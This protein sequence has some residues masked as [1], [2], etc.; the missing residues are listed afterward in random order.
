M[1]KSKRV[2]LNN[3]QLE[4]VI[5]MAQEEKRP[6]EAV[7]YTHLDVYKR[8]IFRKQKK[9][10]RKKIIKLLKTI[11]PI[12]TKQLKKIA[13]LEIRN[14]VKLQRQLPE[15]LQKLIETTPLLSNMF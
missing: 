5:S 13:K 4:R 8:Q 11:I 14:N 7:S 3:E 12:A 1:K 15:K 10:V 2:E 6:F 9:N